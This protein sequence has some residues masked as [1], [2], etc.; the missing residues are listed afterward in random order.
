MSTFA[1]NVKAFNRSLQIR[2]KLPDGIGV[3]NPFRESPVAL[4]CAD[5]FYDKFYADNEPRRLLLGINPGRH[6]GGLTGVPFTDFKRLRDNCGIEVPEGYRSHE[7]SSEFVYEVV[8]ALGGATACYQQLYINSICP[9]GFVLQKAAGKVVNYNYY[10]DPALQS[11]V[12]PFILS[13]LKAQI[14][15]GCHTDWVIVMGK[16]NAAYLRSINERHKL[17]GD[18]REV[19]HPRFIVQYR[20]RMMDVYVAEY[21]QALA[22]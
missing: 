1:D 13:C 7:P 12:E 18:I 14:A 9:L 2:A 8:E 5:A 22:G 19:P 3:L 15:F 11:A 4:T 6:G 21:V 20:R 16:Q 17:F 10:D